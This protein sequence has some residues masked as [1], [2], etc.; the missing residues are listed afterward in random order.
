MRRIGLSITIPN[1]LNREPIWVCGF[2]RSGN[3]WLA[4]LLGDV[5]D[6]PVSAGRKFPANADEGF[7]RPGPFVIRQQHNRP[8]VDGKVV[9]IIR[10]P[11]DITVS[12]MH[13]RELPSLEEALEFG[14]QSP[15]GKLMDTWQEFV[16]LWLDEA[17]VIVK[18]EALLRDPIWAMHELLA[19]LSV[20]Y[21]LD[22]LPDAILRQSF[23]ERRALAH[24]ERYENGRFPYGAEH[25]RYKVLRQGIA[26]DWKNHF[27][28]DIAQR[29]DATFNP[30]MS[31]LGYEDEDEWWKDLP[32]RRD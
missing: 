12:L 19:E 15:R 3:T 31:E 22:R 21:E 8:P 32:L 28:Q 14:R 20:S 26:G 9:S 17:D 10:D 1:Y 11:R 4:R 25:E 18:Y 5:L 6:S 30:V 23:N 27:T 29:A 2:P 24:D 16:S 7:D 13:Y